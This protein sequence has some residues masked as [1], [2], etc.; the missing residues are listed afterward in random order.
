MDSDVKKKLLHF[1]EAGKTDEAIQ[2][3]K[4]LKV[5]GKTRTQTQN[6]IDTRPERTPSQN[7]Q[8]LVDKL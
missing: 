5:K 6:S 7:R 4:L 3:I 8:T 2:F 1:L